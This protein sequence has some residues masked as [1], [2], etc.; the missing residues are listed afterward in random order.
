M[1]THIFHINIWAA[2]DVVDKVKALCQNALQETRKGAD[3]KTYIEE[4]LPELL[5]PSYETISSFTF[6][7]PVD[8]KE[9]NCYSIWAHLRY[10]RPND[11]CLRHI[12]KIIIKAK[13]KNLQTLTDIITAYTSTEIFKSKK[14]VDELQIPNELKKVV[15]EFMPIITAL[16]PEPSIAD[17]SSMSSLPNCMEFIDGLYNTDSVLESSDNVMDINDRMTLNKDNIS[18][19]IFS[20]I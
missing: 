7:I 16:L 8:Q 9:R 12:V 13:Y 4:K 19:G 11:P 15:I 2:E 3:L 17:D 5:E 10:A 20:L 14:D 1:H 18:S 6:F